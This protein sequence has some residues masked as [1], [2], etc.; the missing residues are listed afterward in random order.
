MSIHLLFDGRDE[1][2][3]SEH[4][5]WH[6]SLDDQSLSDLLSNISVPSWHV[7]VVLSSDNKIVVLRHV[8]IDKG[9]EETSVEEL[10]KENSIGN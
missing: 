3:N 8:S 6:Y 1:E 9:K 7:I 5:I 4:D 10:G 2:L